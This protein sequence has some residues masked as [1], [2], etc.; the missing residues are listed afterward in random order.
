MQQLCPTRF[1]ALA[2]LVLCPAVL[3]SA[4]AAQV[5]RKIR[6]GAETGTRRP[7][8]IVI[9]AD[10][11]GCGDMSLYDGWVPTPR[12]DALAKQGVR[13][14][15]FHS[16][17][18]VCSP[19]RVAFLTGRYQQRIGIVDVIV[20]HRDKDGLEPDQVT[21]PSLMKKAGY[22]TAC[23][24]KWH[25]GTSPRHNP[26]RHGF[27]EFIGFLIGGSDYHRH[28]HWMNGTKRE[29]QKGYTTHVITDRSVDF[30]RRNHDRP[31]FLYVSH[32]AV[33]NPYQTPADTPDKRPKKRQRGRKV[34]RPKYK[35]MLEELDKGVGKILD[36]LREF[37]LEEDTL[38]FF[39]SDNGDVR[40]SPRARP[41]RGG[42]FSNYEGGHRVP[43]VARWPGRIPAGWTSNA[44]AVGMDLLPTIVEFAGLSLPEEHKLDGMSLA[45]HLL[46]KEALPSRKVFFGYEPKLGTAM[47]DGDWKMQTKGDVVELYDLS[48][49]I[50][51]SK[52][53]ASEHPARAAAM[54]AA[55]EAWKSEVAPK[56]RDSTREARR[57]AKRA[58]ALR[59]KKRRGV[60]RGLDGKPVPGARVE[61]WFRPC[62]NL[63]PL[64][65]EHSVVTTSGPR[66][67]FE[68]ELREGY[69]YS[70]VATWKTSSGESRCT[71][72][73][74]RVTPGTLLSLKESKRPV[75][76]TRMRIDAH[77]EAAATFTEPRFRI[78]ARG[79]NP[80]TLAQGRFDF[81]AE[82]FVDIPYAGHRGVLAV[83]LY[84]REELKCSF[85][86]F[87]AKGRELAKKLERPRT[88]K[89]CVLDST[90][91]PVAG[92]RI[93]PTFDYAN[94]Q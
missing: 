14:T 90:G 56:E 40:M 77:P 64:G 61:A 48:A 13:F 92:A 94:D 52:N 30:I 50:K 75:G 67:K 70:V 35:V 37:E 23:F 32:A 46:R 57:D 55:I 58:Q 39:F 42:K 63:E 15:D 82:L 65:F 34:T 86:H 81:G 47:R 16:N 20:G 76:R 51:E 43:A 4:L 66:G 38:V 49:D 18:S 60:V 87:V 1:L 11:L 24:G 7:N 19:T 72:L 74:D 93:A 45:P 26:T 78:L 88:W 36:T 29:E 83:E 91:K 10:D 28:R 68:L 22:R 12:I 31:F 25:C 89:F 69:S 41:Y 54:K 17:S 53:L 2:A 33:H 73:L 44:L 59:T 3:C 85:A 80:R 9:L 6:S 84:S 8:V 27:D 5:E 21:I 79:A 71:E 62:V